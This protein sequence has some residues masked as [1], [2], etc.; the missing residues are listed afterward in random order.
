MIIRIQIVAGPLPYGY[1]GFE[2]RRWMESTIGA[3]WYSEHGAEGYAEYWLPTTLS[4]ALRAKLDTSKQ[5]GSFIN[6]IVQDT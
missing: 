6:W 2:L 1:S 5:S 4:D 3:V